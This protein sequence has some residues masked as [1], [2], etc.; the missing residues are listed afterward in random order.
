MKNRSL[1][2]GKQGFTL[3]E[4]VV[5]IGVMLVIVGA[6]M[7]VFYQ[8][9]RSGSRIDFELFMDTSSRVI[10]SSMIDTIGFGRVVSVADQGQDL[11]LA[12]GADGLSGE[13]LVVAVAGKLT[14]YTLENDYIASSSTNPT[15]QIRISPEGIKIK[16][17]NFNWICSSGE[18]EKLKV[19]F[20]A[21]A[22]K[23]D[24]DVPIEKNYSFEVILKNSGYY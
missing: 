7:G 18:T 1:F 17:L 2:A 4:L 20:T 15:N 3:I 8:S 12:A 11:C 13:S 14:E 24:Q 5:V 6:G 9:L 16:T 21:Q 22:E 19:D 23:E 10:E